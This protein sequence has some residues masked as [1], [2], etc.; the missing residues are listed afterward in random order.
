M[1][2][3]WWY[4]LFLPTITLNYI[5][6][7]PNISMLDLFYLITTSL[8]TPEVRLHLF[9]DPRVSAPSIR[10]S[11]LSPPRLRTIVLCPPINFH[12]VTSFHLDFAKGL[13]FLGSRSGIL[14]V[15]D[16]WSGA[17]K[18]V[19]LNPLDS[20]RGWH[21]KDAITGI[22]AYPDPTP[23]TPVV[24]VPLAAGREDPRTAFIPTLPVS[25]AVP[26][27]SRTS[28]ILT[29]GRNGV[30]AILEITLNPSSHSQLTTGHS[31][32]L[33]KLHIKRILNHGSIEGAYHRPPLGPNS[34]SRVLGDLLLYGFSG[35]RF[36][37]Y[38]D[39]RSYEVFS[40]DC[41]GSHRGWIFHPYCE[42]E[43]V[44]W[45]AWT[46]AG[47]QCALKQVRTLRRLLQ[48]GG[49]GREI[50][51][52]AISLP[53]A[54][55][56][57]ELIATGA[58]DTLIRISMLQPQRTEKGKVLLG[59]KTL[60]I[61]KKHTT[62][63]QCLEW[64]SCGRWLFSSGGVEEFY[65][66]RVRRMNSNSSP[67]IS[68][69]TSSSSKGTSIGIGVVHES[70]CPAQSIVPD[71]R[72]PSFAVTTVCV[73]WTPEG[74]GNAFLVTMVYSDSSI[75]IWLYDPNGKTFRMIIAG[76]YKTSCLLHVKHFIHRQELI[77]QI[78]DNYPTRM[79][80]PST[81]KNKSAFL[82][83]VAGTD[84]FVAIWDI[85]TSLW[86]A[87]ISVTPAGA[88]GVGPSELGYSENSVEVP[89]PP[90]IA[91]PDLLTSPQPPTQ[92][93][94][95]PHEG[96][97]KQIHQSGVKSMYILALDTGAPQGSSSDSSNWEDMCG[98]RDHRHS[99]PY[100][101]SNSLSSKEVGSISIVIFTG[102]DD[103]AFAAT[104]FTLTTVFQS[105]QSSFDGTLSMSTTWATKLI[106]SAQASAVTAVV[107]VRRGKTRWTGDVN[108]EPAR[109]V[110]VEVVT[111]GVDRVLMGWEVRL[112]MGAARGSLGK[113]GVDIVEAMGGVRGYSSVADIS[114]AVNMRGILVPQ[115]AEDS[116][117]PP[118]G[119]GARVLVVGVGL[120]IWDVFV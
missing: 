37:V 39:T 86:R 77:Q 10:N 90:L 111:V 46:Q 70:T 104:V 88:T 55:H 69:A 113:I 73:P 12:S 110:V 120:E 49:H 109:E 24:T 65:V 25:V 96:W 58:E 87:G 82:L 13:L 41:A 72:I 93:L 61:S 107:P 38:N 14:S 52:V 35:K 4:V 80:T 60:A 97:S 105:D 116:E 76:R 99:D 102:G 92:V 45:F 91:R 3:A 101:S 11:P 57:T 78:G 8:V 63:I 43:G 115:D 22:Y 26:G 89:L 64:S 75:K 50:K 67:D 27:G 30:F 7:L 42:G 19:I 94:P 112:L 51:A 31:V 59:F 16:V 106:P 1:W 85:T 28:R 5:F 103:A 9:P 6:C 2:K 21:E 68:G 74:Q 108:A 62:G 44:G 15:F 98:A 53:E 84:G 40:H 66:W 81:T 29:T 118:L 83:V 119:G 18:D 34:H 48:M 56:E 20:W 100:Y 17:D 71:L 36:F 95:P 33:T 47:R 32:T 54:G 23:T 117:K 114:G 79:T